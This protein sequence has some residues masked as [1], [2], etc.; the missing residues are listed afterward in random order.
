MTISKLDLAMSLRILSKVMSNLGQS[1]WMAC[2]AR[3]TVPEGIT[4]SSIE[5]CC[6]RQKIS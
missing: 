3:I 5:V 6:L 4:E 2:E 1:H